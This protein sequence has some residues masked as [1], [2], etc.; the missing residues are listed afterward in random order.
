MKTMKDYH[1][2]YLKSEVLLLAD[3]FGKFRNNSLKNYGFSRRHYLSAPALGLDAILN[4]T[5]VELDLISDPDMQI[6]F[7]KG[8]RGGVFYISIRYSKANKVFEIL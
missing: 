6:F 7:E 4:I 8:T 3:V 2:L 5:K 1:N